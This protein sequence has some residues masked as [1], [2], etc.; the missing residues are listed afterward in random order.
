MTQPGIHE[1][2]D[3]R[4]DDRSPIGPNWS[5][6]FQN[7]GRPGP[8]R[9]SK[10]FLGPGPIYDFDSDIFQP[11]KIEPILPLPQFYPYTK[12]HFRWLKIKGIH[13]SLL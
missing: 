3:P 7:F 1:P 9:D 5:D 6:T 12:F 2:P 4:T 11:S 13:I 10:I 8:V